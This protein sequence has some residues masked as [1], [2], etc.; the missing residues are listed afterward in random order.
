VN[1]MPSVQHLLSGCG[2]M[3]VKLFK[4]SLWEKPQAQ[5]HHGLGSVI[6]EIGQFCN[7]VGMRTI[8]IHLQF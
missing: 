2:L 4:P 6:S 7:I 3:T 1:A 8:D 5:Y